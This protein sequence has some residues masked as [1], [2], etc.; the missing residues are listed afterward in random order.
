MREIKF[1][2]KSHAQGTKVNYIEAPEGWVTG[3]LLMLNAGAYI[4][5]QH[6]T[7]DELTHVPVWGNSVGQY[8]GLKNGTSEKDIKMQ[9]MLRELGLL[10]DAI[11][12]FEAMSRNET[13]AQQGTTAERQG[14][15]L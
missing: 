15:T 4:V 9:Q 10:Q 7:N 3:S 11:K 13:T 12:Y 8:T 14:E 5:M 2:G 1:R 6:P